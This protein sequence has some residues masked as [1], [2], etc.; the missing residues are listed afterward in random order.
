LFHSHI[1]VKTYCAT[2]VG[3]IKGYLL[4]ATEYLSTSKALFCCQRFWWD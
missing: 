1:I 4:N 3:F 2:D